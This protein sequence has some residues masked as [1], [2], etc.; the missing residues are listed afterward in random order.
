M[1]RK[2]VAAYVGGKGPRQWIWEAIRSLASQDPLATFT[3]AEIWS[4]IPIAARE[5]IEIGAIRDY[6][7]ALV[8]ASIIDLVTAPEAIGARATY[9]L[10]KDEGLEAPRVRRDGTRVT[11]GLAQE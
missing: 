6:R 9:R 5:T 8:A 3:E 11:Q 1:P 2:S 4:A 7:R 10:A